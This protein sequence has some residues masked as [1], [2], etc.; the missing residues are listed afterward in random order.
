MA[1]LCQNGLWPTAFTT[2]ATQA[3][4]ADA[5][6]LG[7]SEV[8]SVG[9]SQVTFASLPAATSVRNWPGDSTTLLCH[10]GP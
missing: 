5:S 1:V 7:W 4:P 9:V 6:A 8:A 2:L 10:S 3:G